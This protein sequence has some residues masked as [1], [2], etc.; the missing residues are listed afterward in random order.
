M[1]RQVWRCWARSH[2]LECGRQQQGNLLILCLLEKLC[3]LYDRDPEHHRRLF[4][5]ICRSLS[6]LGVRVR[7]GAAVVTCRQIVS[8]VAFLEKS[9]KLRERCVSS[10]NQ[11]LVIMCTN[12]TTLA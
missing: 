10:C 6:R 9:A 12:D 3:R 1:L 7:R 8:N 5:S 2:S 11:A 4:H